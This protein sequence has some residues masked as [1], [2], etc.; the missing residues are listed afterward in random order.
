M[1]SP[2]DETRS[3]QPT[4]ESTTHRGPALGN[5]R[6]V[7]APRH[8]D[9]DRRRDL[10]LAFHVHAQGAKIDWLSRNLLLVRSGR[11][12]DLAALLSC[13]SSEASR[14]FDVDRARAE[15]DVPDPFGAWH[16]RKIEILECGGRVVLRPRD[17][18]SAIGPYRVIC[19][20]GRGAMGEVLLAERPGL[21][22][23]LAIKRLFP[24]AAPDAD[25]L[26]RF[27]REARILGQL[28]HPNIVS[29]VDV[30]LEGREPYLVMDYVPGV[31]LAR[32]FRL[33]LPR[34]Q[35]LRILEAIARALDH[36]HRQGVLHR[37]V[38][39]ANVLVDVEGAAY[40][41]DFGLAVASD[42]LRRLT[43]A[44]DVLGSPAYMAPEVVEGGVGSTTPRSD[45]YSLGVIL[46]EVLVGSH[47]FQAKTL[48]QLFQ[49]IEGGRFVQPRAI[50]PAI[51][52][53]L[54][55]ICLQAMALDPDRRI[56]SAGEFA[57]RLEATRLPRSSRATPRRPRAP[58]VRAARPGR[59]RVVGAGIAV[60][61]VAL[62]ALAY[63][64]RPRE[65]ARE[66][67]TAAVPDVPAIDDPTPVPLPPDPPAW[68][69]IEVADP[70]PPGRWGG[71][72][73]PSGFP[74]AYAGGV[75]D[76][77]DPHFWVLD[78]SAEGG[79]RWTNLPNPTGDFG[80]HYG[81]V[82]V[83]ASDQARWLLLHHV[84]LRACNLERGGWLPEPI[85]N[86]RAPI[87]RFRWGFYEVE[88]RRI[89]VAEPVGADLTLSAL[90]FDGTEWRWETL[91]RFPVEV[92]DGIPPAWDP[93][94]R[95]AWFLGIRRAGGEI[96][97]N[98]FL[99]IDVS[100]DV[101]A[102]EFLSDDLPLHPIQF[103]TFRAAKGLL[104]LSHQTP[105]GAPR[106][107]GGRASGGHLQLQD[108]PPFSAPIQY[109]GVL[110][111]DPGTDS[112]V[113]SGHFDDWRTPLYLWR[114]PLASLR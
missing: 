5:W 14:P 9:P 77:P 92:T 108:L 90:R 83:Y 40:L 65:A 73:E 54:E 26:G 29:I 64:L 59:G 75:S 36:A 61:V 71:S 22:R 10:A 76:P 112:L 33:G 101:P 47:P 99:T 104:V 80:C 46:Y 102:I 93:A 15:R 23:D 34:D 87:S 78:R 35:A 19:S 18:P 25:L 52:R 67:I 21:A 28:S 56:A 82:L 74:I 38:K 39:P 97:D 3:N 48:P 45:L 111:Y 81:S 69:K 107:Q 72:W 32:Q 57:D 30:Q 1:K 106:I 58:R 88:R 13:P 79:A 94:E 49:A 100:G 20:L 27:E 37:D 86:P 44:S 16:E 24:G 96:V 41:A 31:D 89:V 12:P 55:R 60:L 43:C 42:S 113:Y 11:P 7:T 8:L 51:D 98:D 95:K 53:E 105:G 2:M 110:F 85:R 4:E 63:A 70:L 109:Q 84:S 62:A 66:A 68:T 6:A 103:L 17:L 91:A 50:D 114:C